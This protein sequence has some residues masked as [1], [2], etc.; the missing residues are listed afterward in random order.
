MFIGQRRSQRQPLDYTIYKTQSYVRHEMRDQGREMSTFFL[1]TGE[2]EK[3]EG[4]GE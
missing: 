3:N 1:E 2:K 4:R